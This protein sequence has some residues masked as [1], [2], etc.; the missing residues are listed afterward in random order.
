MKP[1]RVVWLVALAVLG[2]WAVASRLGRTWGST[3][4]ERA[5]SLPGDDLVPEPSLG[6]DHAITIDAPRD[7]VW[8]WLLQVGWGRGGWYTYRWVDR[9]LFP[10]NS[11]SADRILPQYQSLSAGDRIPD[12]P[13]EMGCY[14]TV[15][16]IE[17]EHFLV[18]YSTTHLPPSQ[19]NRE[20]VGM[21]WNWT[22]VLEQVGD[23][24]TR[25]HFRWRG[26]A[27]P[28][29]LRLLYQTLVMPADFVMGGC[30]CLGL[31]RRAESATD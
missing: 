11:A 10:N 12:G 24:V 6:G 28:W 4:E 26:E 14:F 16:E 8:P 7:R 13:P 23:S 2:A 22:F 17:H 1:G 20:G 21:S 29:W 15:Q 27:R 3:P 19:L 9:L 30:M 31:K 25:F 5:R 18:L